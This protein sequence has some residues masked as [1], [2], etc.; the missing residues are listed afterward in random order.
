[1]PTTHDPWAAPRSKFSNPI[2][3]CCRSYSTL[4]QEKVALA[5]FKNG[6]LCSK[7]QNECT[8]TSR[9]KILC[10]VQ[11]H[12]VNIKQ[13]TWIFIPGVKPSIKHVT[14]FGSEKYE[15]KFLSSIDLV[16]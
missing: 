16:N 2:E 8:A 9:P 4:K 6:C 15:E 3:N 14:N 7:T 5:F 13:L 11:F 1:M 10:V 12:L